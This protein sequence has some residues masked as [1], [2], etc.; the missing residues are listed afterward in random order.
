M[1]LTNKLLGIAGAVGI[2]LG[3]AGCNK[4]YEDEQCT[5]KLDDNMISGELQYRPRWGSGEF[6]RCWGMEDDYF[7]GFCAGEENIYNFTM[8]SNEGSSAPS[9]GAHKT[10][11]S[12]QLDEGFLSVG[13]TYSADTPLGHHVVSS[14][15]SD[16]DLAFGRCM[17]RWR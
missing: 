14:H 4:R 1:S 2:A 5:I 6:W 13:K 15:I 16:F 10:V 11:D 12:V 7:W 3:V 8:P 9:M 17:P